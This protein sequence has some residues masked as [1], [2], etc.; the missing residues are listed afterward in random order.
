M[1]ARVLVVG[2]AG[3]IGSHMLLAL[4]EAGHAVTTYDNLST[5]H[6]DAVLAGEFVHGDLVDRDR[7][8]QLFARGKFDLVM[9][10][11]ANAYVRESVEEPR[12]YYRNNVVGCLNLLDA[13][14][15]AGVRRLVFS[16]S[17]ATYGFAETSPISETHP[18][19][20]VNPYGFT[21]LVIEHA[22]A[23]YA[24]A[25]GLGAIAL[26]YFNAA[27]ADSQGR[28]S[29]RHDPETHLIPLVLREAARVRDGGDP[30]D[31]RLE[32]F[33]TDLPTPDGSCLRDFVHV[34][35][36]AAA[37]LA[38]AERLFT[39]DVGF[40]AYNIGSERPASVLE[41]I[42]AAR[43]VTGIDVRYRAAAAKPGDPPA[44]VATAA[45][46]KEVLGWQARH[47]S[48]EAILETAWR[49]APF[50]GASERGR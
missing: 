4:A 20:P 38:A 47:P 36:I 23:D 46:A 49:A 27:G 22:L 28:L 12:K 24:T 31:T 1:S 8:G 25:Y 3:Y 44:L 11:A 39:E 9:H 13:M 26:R 42:D 5:G 18:Q 37:H 16:S 29:E 43:R 2:G 30:A 35:D 32:V 40:E 19:R 45:R 14:L 41:V 50:A 34:E 15:D 17:C 33:G 6:R 10:F 48:L 21:K 7:L